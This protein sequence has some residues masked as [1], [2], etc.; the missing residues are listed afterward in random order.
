MEEYL[1]KAIVYP[2]N[3]FLGVFVFSEIQMVMTNW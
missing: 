1:T 2:G 3:I